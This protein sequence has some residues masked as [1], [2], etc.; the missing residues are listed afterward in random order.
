MVCLKLRQFEGQLDQSTPSLLTIM[1]DEI[2][3]QTAAAMDLISG[4]QQTLSNMPHPDSPQSIWHYL[5]DPTSPPPVCI[6][7]PN[8]S[9]GK[10]R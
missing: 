4:M 5:A 6:P 3:L 10:W 7:L 2:P 1:T 8:T 9:S